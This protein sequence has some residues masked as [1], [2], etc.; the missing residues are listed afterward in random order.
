MKTPTFF[1]LIFLF[2]VSC[3]SHGEKISFGNLDIYYTDGVTKTE[4]EDVGNYLVDVG[5]LIDDQKEKM[6]LSKFNGRYKCK[7]VMRDNVVSLENLWKGYGISISEKVLNG[8]PVDV[9]LCDDEFNSLKFLMSD[10]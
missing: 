3:S 5:I 8:A 2:I 10:Y 9:D 6:Q 1:S 4:A 7:F